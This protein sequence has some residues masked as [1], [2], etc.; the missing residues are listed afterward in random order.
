MKNVDLRKLS[1]ISSAER[2]FLSVYISGESTNRDVENALK[3]KKKVLKNGTDDF[4][5]FTENY[6]IITDDMKKNSVKKGSHVIFCC[7][8]L[9]YYKRIELELPV[10]DTIR[11]DSSPYILPLA[12]LE[13]EYENYLV[14]ATSNEKTKMFVVSSMKTI[15]E[16][17][18]SG[19]IKNHV[20]VGG[21]SQQRYER[22]RDKEFSEYSKDITKKIRELIKGIDLRRIVLVGSKETMRELTKELPDDIKKKII[23]EKAL[24]LKKS[25]DFINDEI[26]RLLWKEEKREE[27]NLWNRIKSCYLRDEL[28]VTGSHDVLNFAKQ[29]RINSVIVN[30]SADLKGIRCRDCGELSEVETKECRECKSSSVFPIDLVNEITELLKL[31]GG[32]IEFAEDIDDLKEAGDIAAMLRY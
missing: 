24:D 32:E 17:S 27:K 2:A 13:D 20:K 3:R 11:I 25:D 4:E 21:W 8:A 10:D 12:R 22:R 30:K 7:W 31:S 1:S 9:D 23:G 5:Y 19:N 6:K 15:K 28:G 18:I 26:F 29:G 16:D 14:I